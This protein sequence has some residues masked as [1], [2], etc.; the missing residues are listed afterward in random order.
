MDG[1]KTCKDPVFADLE[2][3]NDDGVHVT[4]T[5]RCDLAGSIGGL[6]Y[7]TGENKASMSNAVV[8]DSMAEYCDCTPECDERDPSCASREWRN[9]ARACWAACG[10]CKPR[11]RGCTFTTTLAR[12]ST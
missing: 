3:V 4:G 9:P 7:P 6:F 10:C 5:V 12:D 1:Y 8:L 11:F 2:A